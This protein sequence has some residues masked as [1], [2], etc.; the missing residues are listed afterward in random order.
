MATEPTDILTFEEALAY[1]KIEPCTL[2]R[3]TR[4]GE[5]PARKIGKRLYYLRSDLLDWFNAQPLRSK[6]G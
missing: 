1:I 2:S 5:L 4:S 6:V 3:V